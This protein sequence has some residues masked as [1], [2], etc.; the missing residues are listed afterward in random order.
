MY[1]KRH[2]WHSM[3]L[4]L[5]WKA[6]RRHRPPLSQMTVSYAHIVLD[7]AF[8]PYMTKDNCF[9]V[10][11]LQ[12]REDHGHGWCMDKDNGDTCLS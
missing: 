4:M 2:T 8:V 1:F 10:F 3:A 6:I 5:Q 12:G 11:S 9:L 7:L